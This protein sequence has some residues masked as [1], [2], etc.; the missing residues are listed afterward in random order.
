M[1]I[2]CAPWNDI[3]EGEAYLSVAYLFVD[4]DKKLC[5][6]M[7]SCG[8]FVQKLHHPSYFKP[9]SKNGEYYIEVRGSNKLITNFTCS[10]IQVICERLPSFHPVMGNCVCLCV[11]VLTHAIRSPSV[12]LSVFFE[13]DRRTLDDKIWPTVPCLSV[14]FCYTLSYLLPTTPL[15]FPTIPLSLN[16]KASS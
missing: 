3:E 9:W 6:L 1:G 12:G 11:C 5:V 14:S 2:V 13:P 10:S 4:E 16:S 15:T 8:E 7:K